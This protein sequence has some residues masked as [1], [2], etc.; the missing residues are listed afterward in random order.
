MPFADASLVS[1]DGTC[2][3]CHAYGEVR[4]YRHGGD[5]VEFTEPP[6]Q[7]YLTMCGLCAKILESSDTWQPCKMWY[8]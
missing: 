1:E 6:G 7:R 5:K 4:L 2:E 3:L 8:E